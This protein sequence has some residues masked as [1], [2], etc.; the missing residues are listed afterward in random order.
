MR[1]MYQHQPPAQHPGYYQ[2]PQWQPPSVQQQWQSP[3]ALQLRWLPPCA[4]QPPPPPGSP[5][6]L[7]PQVPLA[8]VEEGQEAGS[9]NKRAADGL[10]ARLQGGK[11]HRLGAA[12]DRVTVEAAGAG[13]GEVLPQP[14][15]EQEQQQPPCGEA[16]QSTPWLAGAPAAIC[17][18][19]AIDRASAAAG[20]PEVLFL[21]TGSAEPSKYRAASAIQLRCAAVQAFC[22]VCQLSV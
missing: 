19:A 11:R 2:Q 12:T 16:Q 6:V 18:L 17:R 4:F 22:H 3:G 8:Q 1:P 10:K 5:P 21:G 15:Q 20:G 14:P 13:A 7:Q 9:D